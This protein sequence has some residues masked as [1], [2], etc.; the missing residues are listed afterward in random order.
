MRC[1]RLMPVLFAGML[2]L[3]CTQ[4]AVDVADPN[5]KIREMSWSRAFE[6]FW[7]GM[8]YSY[9][10]W[11]ID[12]TDWDA[13]YEEFRPRF[14]ML[15]EITED[16]M[17]AA[18]GLFEEATKSIIDHHYQLTL[19]NPF[20]GDNRYIVPWV[21]E[22]KRRDHFHMPVDLSKLMDIILA[23]EKGGLITDLRGGSSLLKDRTFLT[24]VSCNMDDGVIYLYLNRFALEEVKNS[25]DEPA[26]EAVE[27]FF[28][29]IDGTPNLR[30]VIIDVRGNGGGYVSDMQTLLGELVSEDHLFG[31]SRT[32]SG[33][34]RL[35]YTL[36]SPW[37]VY[38][39][40]NPR[41]ITVPI[42]SLA[43]MH[44]VSMAE[45]LTMA[46]KSLPNGCF[47]GERTRGGLGTLM[48][49]FG[50][51]YAGAFS[52][53]L[54]QV[55]TTTTMSKDR[56][57]NI[58]EGSGIPPTIEMHFDQVSFDAGTD[59]QLERALEYIRSGI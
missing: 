12:P 51:S 41:N 52:N 32:K 43:D 49:D 48:N 1:Y 30:G 47:V 56:D 37:I 46:V 35:D 44:S 15:G 8:N 23:K 36:W 24:A 25:K 17:D 7:N 45:M 4:D 54:F 5:E 57:G 39:R 20:G 18:V 16:N 50:Y 26:W 53:N 11:D 2:C 40:D 22:L 28:E 59:G 21:N 3:S 42:V 6:T 10:F 13:V 31:Y 27:N 14:E 19:Y 29:L 9:V 34:G 55:Y 33:M 38:A 58:Y